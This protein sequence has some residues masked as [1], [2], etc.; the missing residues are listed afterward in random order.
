MQNRGIVIIGAG[1]TGLSTAHNLKKKGH[2]VVIVEKE[3]RIGGQIRTYQEDGFVYESGP[4]TGVVSFPEV[5]EL[6]NDLAEIGRASCR[7]RV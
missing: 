5:V 1:L 6:F 7:E 3:S 4:N 2:D